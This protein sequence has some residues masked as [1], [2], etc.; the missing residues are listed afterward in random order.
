[1]TLTE[2]AAAGRHLVICN[3][4]DSAHPQAGGAELY[5]EEVARHLKRLGARVTLLTS[6]PPGTAAREVT[7]FGTVVRAGGTFGTYPRALLWLFAH[8]RHIDAVIDSENGIPYF[9]PLAVSR[10]TPVALLI[11]HVHQAQFELYFPPLIARLGQLLEKWGMRWVYG[12]RPVCAVSP[13]T[14]AETRRQLALRGATYIVPNGL[15]IS[16]AAG[17]SERSPTPLIVCVGRLVPHKRLALLIEA[18]ARLRERHPDLRVEIVGDGESRA[19]LESDVEQRALGGTIVFRG[20]LDRDE[21]DRLLGS[22]W[23]TVN[24]TAGEGWGLAV[25]EAA[26]HGVPAVA[27][28]VPGMVDSVRHGSTG[29]LVDD[30]AELAEAIDLAVKELS[31]PSVAN[32]WSR[33]CQEW[34]SAFS[35]DSTA[36]RLLAVLTGE[37]ARLGAGWEDR[38]SRSDATTVAEVPRSLVTPAMVAGL[39][40]T[41]QLRTKGEMVEI[42]FGHADDRDAERALQRLGLRVGDSGIVVRIARR[43]DLLGWVARDRFTPPRSLPG[44]VDLTATEYAVLLELAADDGEG[45]LLD[46]GTEPSRHR[47]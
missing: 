17:P 15:S 12:W 33:R 43:S 47:R 13:S 45:G 22:A 27:F 40:V 30:G 28:N 25:L 21:R 8:R 29:W 32:V 41:D 44:G 34:A 5:C 31:D 26:A 11:H 19:R 9:S 37:R 4:R 14:R 24:S 10:R 38:R 42:L 35:W 1:M 20:R 3:W 7:D 6:R 18:V 36:E 46:T 2:E 23:L 16:E 39:R